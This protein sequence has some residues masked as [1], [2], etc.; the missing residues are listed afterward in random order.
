[1]TTGN[2]SYA[3]EYNIVAVSI[4]NLDGVAIDVLP[5]IQGIVIYEDLFSPFISGTLILKDAQDLPNAIG[6]LGYNVLNISVNTPGM[7]PEFAIDSFFF[8]Y[9]LADREVNTERTQTYQFK[10]ISEEGIPDLKTYSRYHSGRSEDIVMDIVRNQLNSLKQV[11]YTP[12]ESN[13]RF[14]SNYWSPSKSLTY[15]S[16][17]SLSSTV[18]AAS[19]LFYENRHGFNFNPIDLFVPTE[20]PVIQTFSQTDHFANLLISTDP[21]SVVRNIDLDYQKILELNIDESF[22]YLSDQMNGSIRTRMVYCDP[23]LKRFNISRHNMTLNG[24]NRILNDSRLYSNQTVTATPY[25]N[26]NGYRFFNT[27]DAGDSSNIRTRQKRVSQLM[28]MQ[29]NKIE[30]EVFGRLDYTVGKKVM[31]DL[32]TLREIEKTTDADEILDK[33]YSGQYIISAVSHRFRNDKHLATL[34][35]I[36]D[37]TLAI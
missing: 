26:Y 14:V 1:M 6:R 9:A 5:Q 28:T 30:I 25:K 13:I 21:S 34:E 4:S 3:G 11:I 35:L 12:T 24:E 15:I 2:I 8:I 10:F 7:A 36:K 29:A 20:I 33:T 31:V 19:Y 37:S 23:V 32:N 17:H 18:S 22:N 16:E 27:F